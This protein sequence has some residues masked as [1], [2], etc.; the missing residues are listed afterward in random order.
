[1]ENNDKLKEI[2][3][4][5]AMCYYFDEIIKIEVFH[6]NNISL[7]EKSYGN[8]FIS[9]FLYKTLS[10]QKHCVLGWMK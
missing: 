7:D 3:I 9:D 1:M 8:I 5:N 4:K 10:V 6:F 2:N